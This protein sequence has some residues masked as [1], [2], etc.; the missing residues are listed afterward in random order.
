MAGE[1]SE[2]NSLYLLGKE[3]FGDYAELVCTS[4]YNTICNKQLLTYCASC[5]SHFS[6]SFLRGASVWVF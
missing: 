5:N 1:T 4:I 2:C 6:V 3:K